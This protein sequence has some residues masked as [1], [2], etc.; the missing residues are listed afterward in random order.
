MNLLNE[1]LE[2]VYFY[3]SPCRFR[4]DRETVYIFKTRQL[5]QKCQKQSVYITFIDLNKAFEKGSCVRACVA[6]EGYVSIR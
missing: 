4:K 2:N 1:N 6:L 5:L 3:Q